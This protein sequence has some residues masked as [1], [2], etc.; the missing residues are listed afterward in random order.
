MKGLNKADLGHGMRREVSNN[1][2]SLQLILE[3]RFSSTTEDGPYI[4]IRR[5][6]ID[7]VDEHGGVLIDCSD[8]EVV[9]EQ[10]I[11]EG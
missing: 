9:A 10:L 5:E 4:Q 8:S 6:G 7:L 2:R 11:S 1:L 3:H